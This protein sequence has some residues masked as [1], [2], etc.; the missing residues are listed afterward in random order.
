M[1]FFPVKINKVNFLKTKDGCHLAYDI[2][3]EGPPLVLIHGWTFDRKMWSPHISEL[4]HYFKTIIYD[5]RGC[6]ESKGEPDLS[7]DTDD[8]DDLLNHLGIERTY[9]LGMSQGG[10]IALRYSIRYPEKVKAIILQGAPLDGYTPKCNEQERIPLNYYSSLAKIGHI[11]TIRNEWMSHPLMHIPSSK[12][13]VK[14]QVLKMINRYSAR[15]LT[16]EGLENM[17]FPI[18]I[19][20][21]LHQITVPTL[22]IE[23]NE[24]TLMLKDVANKLL[25]GIPNSKKIVI[26][27]GGHLIN[28]VEP[29]KYNQAVIEFISE[30]QSVTT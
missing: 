16:N 22:I 12:P 3:G 14:R 4:S 9:L 28:F 18:N 5:R 6:G 13:S 17:A 11:Q 25:E 7:K 8:L 2:K 26:T 19:A 24:E 15:D 10:R 20:E 23:G 29:E 27:G 21:N 30:Q 1:S